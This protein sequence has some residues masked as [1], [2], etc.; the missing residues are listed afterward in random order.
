MKFSQFL[1]LSHSSTIPCFRRPSFSPSSV[2]FPH[3][4]CL[5]QPSIPHSR[6]M[7]ITSQSFFLPC[8]MYFSKFILFMIIVLLILS[9][10]VFVAALLQKFI[11]VFPVVFS[12][13]SKSSHHTVNNILLLTG[14]E[15]PWLQICS[16]F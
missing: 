8:I 14:S 12:S 10:L 7:C 15:L 9:H 6:H 3:R 2:C 11:C 13:L 4:H 1:A 5:W 16:V